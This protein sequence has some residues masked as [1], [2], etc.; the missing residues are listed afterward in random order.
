MADPGASERILEAKDLRLDEGRAVAVE[1]LSFATNGEKVLVFGAS[2][3]IFRAITTEV[4]VKRGELLVAGRM[5]HA[6]LRA[7]LAAIAPLDPKLPGDFTP[8]DY[9]AW[10]AR[11]AAPDT[12]LA[13][14]R[15][16]AAFAA[17]RLESV[18]KTPLLRCVSTARRATVLA[19][20]LAT[21]ARTILFEDPTSGLDDEAARGFAKLVAKAFE[22]VRW[23]LF[24]SRIALESPLALEAD[25]AVVLGANAVL[26]QGAPADLAARE[27]RFSIVVHGDAT[28][29]AK[30]LV[31]Q[32]FSAVGEA[33]RL[34]VDLGDEPSAGTRDLFALALEHGVTIVE[35]SPVAGALA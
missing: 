14:K 7:G 33:P 30:A 26:A 29:F 16:A 8:R 31:A 21:G 2:A 17:F 20:A 24:A 1:G 12:A 15:A 25:D 19:A 11:L 9:V 35:L 10:S 6:S 28:A 27:R 3:P 22:N 34:L 23:A 13:K 4:P 5:P 32:G 18:E